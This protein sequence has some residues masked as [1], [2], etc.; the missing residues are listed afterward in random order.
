[1][2]GRLPAIIEPCLR[3]F[4]SQQ[5]PKEPPGP[6]MSPFW[7]TDFLEFKRNCGSIFQ[8]FPM[9]ALRI[10]YRILKEFLL[11]KALFGGFS[12]WLGLLLV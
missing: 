10:F 5:N 11:G 8:D 6:S 1:M 2:L 7:P 3:T 9:L 4:F 12:L